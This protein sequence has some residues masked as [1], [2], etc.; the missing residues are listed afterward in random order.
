[1]VG[2]DV[3]LLVVL[4][5]HLLKPLFDCSIAEWLT[6]VSEHQGTTRWQHLSA[7]ETARYV[8]AH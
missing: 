7:S 6:P 5:P 4:P 1:M 8:F 2:E 3:F